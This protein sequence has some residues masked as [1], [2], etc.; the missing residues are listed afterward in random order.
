MEGLGKIAWAVARK[1]IRGERKLPAT[2]PKLSMTKSGMQ[3]DKN[4]IN[5]YCRVCGFANNTSIPVTYAAMICRD[6]QIHLMVHESFPFPVMG[7]VHLANRIEQYAAFDLSS[8]LSLS[9]SLGKDLIP[10]DKGYCCDLVCEFHCEETSRL[11]WR[12]TF[13]LFHHQK[14]DKTNDDPRDMYESQIKQSDLDGAREISRWNIPSHKG[15]EYAAVSGDYN[16]IHL[17]A[18]S[19]YLFGFRGGAIMH[20][21][22][23]KAHA[24]A[25]VLPPVEKMA[26]PPVSA[27]GTAPPLT[28]VYVE[29]KTPLFLPSTAVLSCRSVRADMDDT[30]RR[31]ERIFEVKGAGGEEL[32]HMR[33]RC[34]WLAVVSDEEERGSHGDVSIVDC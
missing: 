16:P 2:L 17:H 18:A 12:N 22:W 32:P 6:L 23:T 30:Y 29:F 27:D 7:L 4:H 14:R 33:G 24:L 26:I 13:T 8:K 5:E 10:H 19:A 34:S 28:E 15:R 25:H 11:M 31:E 1:Q 9:V 21:M 20:G 3:F